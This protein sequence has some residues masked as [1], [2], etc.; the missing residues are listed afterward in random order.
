VEVPFRNKPTQAVVLGFPGETEIAEEKLK[1]VERVL[2]SDPLIDD[3]TFRFLK[4]TAE[5]YCHPLGE[6]MASALPKQYLKLS[7]KQRQKVEALAADE[8]YG[9]E[10]GL[11][12]AAV[13]KPVLTE[14]Q[15]QAVEAIGRETRPVL[16]QGVTGSGKTEVYMA[17]LEKALAEGK[18]AIVLV[19]EIALTPQ[20]LGRFSSR[21]PGK[22]AVLH[23]DI[24]PKEKFVQ[25]E[26]IR[27]G[28]A[29][30]VVGARSAVFAPLKDIGLIVVDE[31][32]ET[33]Y[34]QEDSLRYHARD[35]AIVRA[36]LCGAKVVL[37]TA[38]P[39]LESYHNAL[40]GKYAHVRLLKRVKER[41]M[42]KTTFVDLRVKEAAYSEKFPWISN[43]LV[44]KMHQALKNGH[45][46]MLF[47][48]RLGYAHFLF[49]GDCGHT[50]RC[51][52]CDVA[53]TYYRYPPLL[54]C[55]Y[56]GVENEPPTLC[57]QCQGHSLK[58][59]GLGTEQV[60]AALA[61]IFPKARTCRMDRSVVK[62]R[63]DLEAVLNRIVRREVDIVV[64]TQMIAKGH[65][66]PGIA[67]VGVLVADAS[68]NLPDFR[69]FERTFQILTQVSGRAGRAEVAGEVVIQTLNP[70]HPVLVAAAEHR[71][72]D[73][74]R[75]ELMGRERFGFP[76]FQRLAMIRF[77]HSNAAKVEQFA[78]S[79]AGGIRDAV[80]KRGWKC[81]VIGPAE[82]PIA[83]IKNLY[84]WHCL[85]KGGT[86]RELQSVLRMVHDYA[87]R[88]KYPVQ[89][90][91]DVDPVS[92]L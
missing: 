53:L 85:V 17:V 15:A 25:W 72:E 67:L 49:C 9:S 33:S 43:V 36:K 6:V 8:S 11:L 71:E 75:S 3:Q 16:L 29:R 14:A 69:A 7:E 32:H 47:L 26:R 74:F 2:F 87:E 37:G 59:L 24:T 46:V 19:P 38:T 12:A 20:L 76:P 51:L 1:T 86:V 55:H 68:L 54:K 23:S 42:P 90:A 62:T 64:G 89:M 31:E 70:D 84:R 61:E 39:S 91:V 80:K 30:V 81:E 35:L 18:G 13:P 78:L 40:A 28:I 52:N 66:F 21:F 56:C 79:V 58:E 50:W 57:E 27:R 45:Q 34:K 65:D 22:V 5:Y 10:L 41:P 82:A 83:K 44:G 48:N 60:E 77:Q 4:W 92:S 88:L 73:F 63:K